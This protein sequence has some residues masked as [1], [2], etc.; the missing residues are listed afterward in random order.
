MLYR[1][2]SATLKYLVQCER[3]LSRVGIRRMDGN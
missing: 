3:V 1:R 2:E